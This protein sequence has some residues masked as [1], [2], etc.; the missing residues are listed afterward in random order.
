MA[1]F[2]MLS[3]C[4]PSLPAGFDADAARGFQRQHDASLRASDSPLAAVAS[5]YLA[6]GDSVVWTQRDGVVLEDPSA[7]H[8]LELRMGEVFS[9]VA[10]CGEH[11]GPIRDRVSLSWGDLQLTVA[12]Q[13]TGNEPGGRVLAFDP[14]ATALTSYGGRDWYAVDTAFIVPARFEAAANEVRVA[15]ATSRGSRKPFVMVGELQFKLGG[16]TQTLQAYSMLGAPDSADLLVPFTDTTNGE[17]TYRVGRYLEVSI[18]SGGTLGLDFNRATNPWCAFSD[19]YNCPVPPAKNRL[20]VAVEA[21]ERY[22]H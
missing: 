20:A 14:K 11:T 19:H 16:V 8:R 2:G 4:G 18:A 1:G 22:S 7:Q 17:T 9:C 6:P 15:L 10:G 21:G 12:P 5:S 13:H 3:G